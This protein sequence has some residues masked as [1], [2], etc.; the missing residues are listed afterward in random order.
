MKDES[1]ATEEE[2]HEFHQALLELVQRGEAY[3]TARVDADGRRIFVHSDFATPEDKEFTQV[4][5]K[6]PHFS[7]Q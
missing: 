2:L 1:R 4:W 7:V 5:V 6:D 3:A